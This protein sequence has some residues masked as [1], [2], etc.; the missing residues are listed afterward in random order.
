MRYET[1]RS[2]LFGI[3]LPKLE[4]SHLRSNGTLK[5]TAYD[6]QI[7]IDE[8]PELE[9]KYAHL[10][11]GE[12]LLCSLLRSFVSSTIFIVIVQT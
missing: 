3:P 1:A 4:N 2:L 9:A 12:L 10:R 7:M 5:T 6:D 8:K 11:E